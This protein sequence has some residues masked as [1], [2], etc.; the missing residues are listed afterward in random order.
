MGFFSNLF[1]KKKQAKSSAAEIKHVTERDGEPDIMHVASEDDRMNWAIE[2]A[3]LTLDYFKTSLRNP[4][5][6]QQYLSIKAH[7]VDGENSEHIWLT[8]PTFDEQG[9]IF[10][11]LGNNPIYV[12][13]LKLGQQIGVDANQISDWM[14]IENGRLIGGYTIRAIRDGMQGKKRDDFD[15]STGMF[16][17][18]GVDYFKHNFDTPEGAIL[19][20]E[21]AYDAKD[22]NAALACKNFN[23][24]GRMMAE[25]KGM[26]ADDG[27]ISKMGE[28]LRLSFVQY[29]QENGFPSFKGVQRAFPH[30][31][32]LNDDLYIITEI[33]YNPDRTKSMQKHYVHRSNNEWR[34]LN[35][36]E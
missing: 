13:H 11:K 16:I 29:H 14:I 32:K 4:R 1:G 3:N 23:E 35:L 28:L 27:V 30:R 10:G 25:S 26:P 9:N 31:Q 21:D 19:C 33:C 22:M 5:Q 6:D 8:D 34:V 20:L 2:K 7:L 12:K 36:V 18:E 24:E 17:D 15:K